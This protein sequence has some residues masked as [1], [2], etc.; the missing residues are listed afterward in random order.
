MEL[1][2]TYADPDFHRLHVADGLIT[3]TT[4]AMPSAAVDYPKGSDAVALARAI[5]AAAGDTG[6][7][8]VSAEDLARLT[9]ERDAAHRESLDRAGTLGQTLRLRDDD[10]RTIRTL[11]RHLADL[12]V[13]VRGV[14]AVA[15]S[16][17]ERA[18]QV[19]EG[20][21]WDHGEDTSDKIRAL[22]LFPDAPR[23]A[24]TPLTA[25]TDT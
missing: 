2:H 23:P 7:E 13:R 22:P 17:R 5:L 11:R 14:E 8:V 19:C 10:Q 12:R 9:S 3:I 16:M 18:A 1:P 6:H 4:P 15:E 24:R 21:P 25:D 20:N